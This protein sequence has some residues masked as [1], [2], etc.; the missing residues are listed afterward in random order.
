MVFHKIPPVEKGTPKYRLFLTRCKYQ[1]YI[2]KHSLDCKMFITSC[3]V[4]VVLENLNVSGMVKNRRLSKSIINLCFR[5]FRRQICYKADAVNFVN[6][7]A[8]TSKTCSKCGNI[9]DMPLSVRIYE[10]EQ[11][12]LILDRDH[13]AAINIRNIG[14]ERP[15]KRLRRGSPKVKPVENKPLA[16]RNNRE[17]LSVKQESL[18]TLTLPLKVNRNI[19][20][21]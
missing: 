10:C 3:I 19:S 20:K 6:R 8:P 14:L 4:V 2:F 17:S 5:E 15:S 9:Q 7:F 12:G 18:N 13:N 11:C 21:R 1:F 16:V